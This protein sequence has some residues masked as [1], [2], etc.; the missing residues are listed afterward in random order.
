MNKKCFI[1]MPLLACAL[2]V[3]AQITGSDSGF[4]QKPK[5]Q[6]QKNGTNLKIKTKDYGYEFSL[7]VRA[8]IGVSMMNE[9]GD[10]KVY[11]AKGLS[12][13]GGV[14]ANVRFGSTDSRGRAIH[15]QGLFGVGLELN[16]KSYSVKT[17]GDDDLKLGYF[18]VPLMF[19]LYPL[20]NSKQ[21]KNLYIELGPTF[22]G[23]LSSSPDYLNVDNIVYKTGDIKGF[24]V[25]ATVGVGY[26]FNK[27]SANDGFYFNARYYFG[28]SD[29]A[30]NF[31]AKIGSAELSIG[32]TFRCLGGN[33]R[34]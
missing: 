21:L 24:D 28:T 2:S 6:A 33:K 10:L 3:S 18:E 25:K 16:Y 23:T 4:E 15:G 30:G 34:K 32:Y 7:G 22:A 12:Y 11:D 13:G 29:L 19:Q 27:A 8:G 1:T 26:R 5:V 31:P 9:G 17:L 14:A 20:Y